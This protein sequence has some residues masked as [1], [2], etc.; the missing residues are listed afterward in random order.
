MCLTFPCDPSEH[1]ASAFAAAL[2]LPWLDAPA[3][4]TAT[5][6]VMAASAATSVASAI[7]F[8]I[9]SP[10]VAVESVPQLRDEPR[11]REPWR[12]HHRG[13]ADETKL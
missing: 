13:D 8:L 11:R 3:T 7:G 12:G 10:S 4:W 1:D 5:S 9:C 6:A 2:L